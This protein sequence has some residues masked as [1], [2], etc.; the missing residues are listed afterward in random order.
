MEE[1]VP[2]PLVIRWLGVSGKLRALGRCF[3]RLAGK[4]IM[5]RELAT[6]SSE[7]RLLS[8]FLIEE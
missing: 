6:L 3:L 5:L 8:R 4:S 2:F 1:G 7:L